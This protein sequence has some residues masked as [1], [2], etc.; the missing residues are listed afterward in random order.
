MQQNRSYVSF[1]LTIGRK[2]IRISP[3]GYGYLFAVVLA[4]IL[5]GAV[6]YNNNL[7]FLLSF[8][9]GGMAV[10]SVLHGFRNIHAMQIRSIT[11]KPVF[12]GE[13]A[14]F[15]VL[16]QAG[17][18]SRMNLCFQLASHAET[19]Q[20]IPPEILQRISVKAPALKRGIFRGGPLLI[21]THFPLGL[22]RWVAALPLETQT[23]VYPKP[24]SGPV[25]KGPVPASASNN[26][27]GQPYP[28]M[29]DFNELQTYRPG[30]PLHHIYWKAFSREQGLH[31]KGFTET[32]AESIMFDWDALA[33]GMDVE[34]RLSRLCHMVLEAHRLKL[35]YGLKLP[36]RTI[37]P[38]SGIT[39]KQACLKA[40]ALH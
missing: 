30:D 40:L 17:K 11:G 34:S 1:P 33:A 3:T 28:G 26:H 5:A 23:L 13:T 6:N 32:T 19:R 16:A 22:V 7:A 29:G 39:H 18:P 27:D 36:G 8:L 38:D 20:D 14:T 24:I 25:L 35:S 10:V 15:E 4:A 12:A 2:Q 9:L 21:S 31:V 37:A